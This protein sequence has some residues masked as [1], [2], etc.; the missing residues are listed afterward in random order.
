MTFEWIKINRPRISLTSK[1]YAHPINIQI[2]WVHDFLDRFKSRQRTLTNGIQLLFIEL[3]KFRVD[4][5]ARW[6][7]LPLFDKMDP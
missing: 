3:E 6:L 2:C 4:V 1:L 7:F 5:D